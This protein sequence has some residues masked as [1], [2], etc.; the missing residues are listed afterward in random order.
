MQQVSDIGDHVDVFE[1]I[2]AVWNAETDAFS[3]ISH[4][5]YFEQKAMM[6]ELVIHAVGERTIHITG[7]GSLISNRPKHYSCMKAAN[8]MTCLRSFAGLL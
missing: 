2:G 8:G 7:I 1:A 5:M 6:R 3:K 4:A